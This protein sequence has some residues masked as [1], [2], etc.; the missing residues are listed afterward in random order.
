MKPVIYASVGLCLLGA[1]AHAQSTSTPLRPAKAAERQAAIL[2]IQTQLNAFARDDY[3][4]AII[5]QSAG[6]KKNFATPDA[7]RTMIVRAYPEFAH[8]KSVQFGAA[9]A[10]T[11]GNHLA[12]PVAVTGRDGITV[13]ALYFLVRENKTYRIEGVHG[14]VQAPPD[15][16]IGVTGMDV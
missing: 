7:F 16:A 12:I 13:R 1:C 3:K 4:T 15:R 11:T 14:G 2:S 6:L 9:R 8:F 5:Y 10:D